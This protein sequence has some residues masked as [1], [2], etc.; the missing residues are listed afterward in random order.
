MSGMDWELLDRYLARE[1]SAEE[2]LRVE[3]WMAEAPSNRRRVELLADATVT[4][5]ATPR[6]EVWELIERQLDAPGKSFSL[7]SQPARSSLTKVAVV[8]LVLG[9]GA[10]AGRAVFSPR[11]EPSTPAPAMRVVRTPPGQRAS[12]RLPDGTSVMLGVASTLRHPVGF[13]GARREVELE[14]EAYFEVVHDES[15]AFAVRAGDIVAVDLGTQ[16]IVRAYRDDHHARVVV[17]EGKVAL[18]AASAQD[19]SA[20]Q[21]L[22]PGQLGRLERNGTPVAERVDTSVYFAWTEGRLVFDD[23]PLRDALPQ[24]SRWYDL[25]FRLADSSLGR[26]PLTATFRNQPTED[27]LDLLAASLGMRQVRSGRTVTFYSAT[28]GR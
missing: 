6:T 16:F 13:G 25:E 26:V 23:V 2:R 21:V 4:A 22:L 7:A 1:C 27:V 17:R 28:S 3:R 14:G 12:F 8:L 19:D 9:V 20:Q 5:P 15:R 24:L 10:L 18:R 11:P